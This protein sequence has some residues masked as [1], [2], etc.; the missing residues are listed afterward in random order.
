MSVRIKKIKPKDYIPEL[1]SSRPD[2]DIFIGHKY[3]QQSPKH[4]KL[5]K[6]DLYEQLGFENKQWPLLFVPLSLLGEDAHEMLVKIIEPLKDM[7]A[8]LIVL[9]EEN[10]DELPG[11]MRQMLGDEELF[12]KALAAAEIVLLTGI[13][14]PKFLP[15]ALAWRYAAV[16]ILP[17][18]TAINGIADDYDPVMEHGSSFLYK[19]SSVW[20]LHRAIIRSLETMKLPYDWRSVQQN[21]TES[22]W[23]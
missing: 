5:N 6:Y 8:Y 17:I 3:S 16:P 7:E 19:Q 1:I 13:L 21:A 18:E 4:K 11:N 22:G 12:H 15:Q 2:R 9:G 10:L 14:K 20:S 23:L